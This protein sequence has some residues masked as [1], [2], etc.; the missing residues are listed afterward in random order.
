MELLEEAS[1]LKLKVC[2]VG[3]EAVGKTSLVRRFV[4]HQFEEEYLRTIGTLISKKTVAV[5][6]QGGPRAL[7]ADLLIWDI[8]GHRN[9]VEL[10]RD[11][12]FYKASGILAVCDVTRARTVA[13]LREWVRG[14]WGAA[15]QVPVVVMAN[16]VDLMPE[17]ATVRE[18]VGQLAAELRAPIHW[19]SAKTGRGVE[20]AFQEAARIMA[21]ARLGPLL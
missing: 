2:L 9:F 4:L 5:P 10:L 20:G 12:Y 21:E 6:I 11:A 8:M 17:S 16:K 19:T 18:A 15:G 13:S 3:D 7:Q 1:A 14:G